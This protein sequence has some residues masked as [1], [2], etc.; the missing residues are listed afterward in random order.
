MTTLKQVF[1]TF[2]EE[3]F[4][5]E[6]AAAI[7]PALSLENLN[8][9]LNPVVVKSVK[10]YS[11]KDT[12]GVVIETVT[13]VGDRDRV[14]IQALSNDV[15]GTICSLMHDELGENIFL[16]EESQL[17]QNKNLLTQ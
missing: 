1:S 17:I 10:V 16:E 5:D 6:V 12:M 7:T 14:Q 15:Y 2:A 9:Y 11:S 3:D 4:A 8:E 13:Y